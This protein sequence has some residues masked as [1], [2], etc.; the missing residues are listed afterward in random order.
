MQTL[1]SS[2]LVP[3]CKK[4][5][6]QVPDLHASLVHGLPS[7]QSPTPTQLPQV[8]VPATQR[9][10]AHA[11][12][13]VQGSPSSQLAPS[14][15]F[16]HG[17]PPLPPQS[18]GQE[19]LD[20]PGSHL[21]LPHCPLPLQSMAQDFWSS[22]NSQEPLPHTGL[23]SFAQLLA[24]SVFWQTPSPQG[25]VF[26]P[27]QFWSMQLMVDSRAAIW[28]SLSLAVHL[29]PQT[30]SL[31][32]RIMQLIDSAQTGSPRHAPDSLWHFSAAQAKSAE[33]CLLQSTG[34]LASSNGLQIASPHT[35]QSFGQL[36]RVSG[37]PGSHL[38]S[39]H[40]PVQTSL[41]P[42]HVPVTHAPRLHASAPAQTLPSLPAV[43]THAPA[44][45]ASTVHGLA[46]SHSFFSPT[47]M[48]PWHWS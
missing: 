6:L 2:H 8:F 24:S 29:A 34:H 19:P 16:A 10:T 26:L 41:M 12:L 17:L 39:P 43:Y 44:L 18:F 32:Q 47:Q 28:A 1:P 35:A 3:C 48:P 27:L 9:P 20:S 14:G 13:T 21:P 45:H 25:A 15:M 4:L 23:Q 37:T 7:S 5:W 31:S 33:T 11:S 36:F 46:S 42:A 22:P 30:S 40:G 38:P